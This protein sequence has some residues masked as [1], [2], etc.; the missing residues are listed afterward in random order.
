M[1]LGGV[2]CAAGKVFTPFRCV[3]PWVRE[4][5]SYL[6]QVCTFKP[7]PSFCSSGSIFSWL[8]FSCLIIFMEISVMT[9]VLFY[10]T[11]TLFNMKWYGVLSSGLFLQGALGEFTSWLLAQAVSDD[12]LLYVKEG[13]TVLSTEGKLCHMNLMVQVHLTWGVIVWWV[14]FWSFSHAF[15]SSMRMS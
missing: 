11:F 3:V 13:Q 5:Y 15:W 4:N 2:I 1:W 7:R 6:S 10:C 9:D 12:A 8:T 14:C